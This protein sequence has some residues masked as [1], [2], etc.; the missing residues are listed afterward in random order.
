MAARRQWNIFKMLNENNRRPIIEC[1][2][3]LY[4]Q[5]KNGIK[6]FLD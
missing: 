3:K 2:E 5:N 1:S 4:F 6:T